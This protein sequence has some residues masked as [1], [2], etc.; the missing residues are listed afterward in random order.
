LPHTEGLFPD[1]VLRLSI[2]DFRL[3][4]AAAAPRVILGDQKTNTMEASM[5]H[6]LFALGGLALAGPAIA[7]DLGSE[8]APL[9]TP[10]YSPIS[11]FNWAGGYLGIQGGYDWN[12]ATTPPSFA[13]NENGGIAG[14][15]GGYNWQTA[16]NWVFGVDAS[17][18]WDGARG[19]DPGTPP[20]TNV[21][22]P[23][24]KGFLRG[25]LGYAWDRFMVYGTAGG[26]VM[27]Y[28]ATITGPTGSGSATPWGWTVGLG[29]EMA[30]TD[31]WVGR[32]DYAYQNYGSFTLAGAAPVGGTSVAVNSHTLMVGIARKF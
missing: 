18:N 23:S 14:I 19:S 27:G 13:A 21:A 29:A 28:T 12:Y 6:F 22:G 15:Y 24:W 11:A 2:L 8:P 16:S 5:R 7:A 31:N 9:E 30:I 32:L 17:V 25:R 4:L 10:I 1:H 3:K 26:A 20:A